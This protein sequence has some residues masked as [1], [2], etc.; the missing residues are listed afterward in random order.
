MFGLA[1]RE[2]FLGI[3]CVFASMPYVANLQNVWGGMLNCL[4]SCFYDGL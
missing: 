3:V 4:L 1:K 2:V